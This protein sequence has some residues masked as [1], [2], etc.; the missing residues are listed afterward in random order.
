MKRLFGTLLI[1]AYLFSATEIHQL[2][3][4]PEFFSHYQE[5]SKK[6]STFSFFDFLVMH[7]VNG[8]FP[9]DDFEKDMDL[10]FKSEHQHLV[11]IPVA[12][13]IDLQYFQLN[14]PPPIYIESSFG[15]LNEMAVSSPL[16]SIWQPPKRA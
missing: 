9:D 10:P 2:V 13:I 15:S 4:L 11:D 3:K 8:N 12:N 16:S 7:Y 14:I 6:D 1:M 5:H